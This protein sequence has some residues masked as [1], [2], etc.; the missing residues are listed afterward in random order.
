M[1]RPRPIVH[2]G[3]IRKGLLLI[4]PFAAMPAPAGSRAAAQTGAGV[5]QLCARGVRRPG[6]SQAATRGT[7][8]SS[9]SI[10]QAAAPAGLYTS[11]VELPICASARAPQSTL[12]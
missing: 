7:L 3:K 9:P 12:R 5:D 8:M 11:S 2:I 10:S 6:S 1:T 4:F